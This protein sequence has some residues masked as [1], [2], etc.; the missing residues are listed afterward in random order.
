[1]DKGDAPLVDADYLAT[2]SIAIAREIGQKMLERRP[3]DIDKATDFTVNLIL[4][5]VTALPRE[6]P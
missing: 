3:I 6:T 2:A 1:M 4:G 5:G